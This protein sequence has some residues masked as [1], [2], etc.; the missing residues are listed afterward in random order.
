M[1]GVCGMVAGIRSRCGG[2]SRVFLAEVWVKGAPTRVSV[3][4]LCDGNATG[5]APGNAPRYST[6]V[7]PI[8][9]IRADKSS[10]GRSKELI[11]SP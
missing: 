2:S 1:E 4:C 10:T 9:L 3:R 6:V 5:E 11:S 8:H 7:A